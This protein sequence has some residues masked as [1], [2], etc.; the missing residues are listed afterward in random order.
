MTKGVKRN[1][2]ELP[3]SPEDAAYVRGFVIHEDSGIIAFNKPSGLAVQTRNPE[4][5]TLDRLMAA[6]ARSNGNVRASSTA[7]TRPP[8][9]SS[10][11][12]RPSRRP[13]P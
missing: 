12:P 3:V 7:S 9:A 11:Q 8:R 13:P 6:F 2:E 1:Y 5:R 10:S 4:D